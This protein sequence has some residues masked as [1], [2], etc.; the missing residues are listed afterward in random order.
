MTGR[1]R[2]ILHE[3]LLMRRLLILGLLA[4]ALAAGGRAADEPDPEPVPVDQKKLQGTWEITSLTRRGAMLKLPA[5]WT[6][7]FEKGKMSLNRGAGAAKA[8]TWKI[9]A[10]K[11]PRQIDMTA[12]VFAGNSY[13]IYKLDK[14]ELTIAS[15]TDPKTRPKDFASADMT[16]V[17]RRTKK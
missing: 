3:G 6:M 1:E 16:M 4:L 14:D 8:G 11:K 15:S 17:L 12:G 10:R 13:G 9:D 5:G 2:P 7:T